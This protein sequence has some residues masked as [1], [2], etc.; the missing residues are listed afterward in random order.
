MK[1]RLLSML[2]AVVIGAGMLPTTASA[3]GEGYGKYAPTGVKVN[4]TVDEL[5]DVRLY[6]T[7]KWKTTDPVGGLT[8]VD[9]INK[10]YIEMEFKNND[11]KLGT[12]DVWGKW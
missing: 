2:L 4:N 5:D 6:V 1:K 7:I 12:Y 9:N 11:V 3:A 8:D 10:S